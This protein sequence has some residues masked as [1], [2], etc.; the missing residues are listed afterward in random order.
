MNPLILCGMN[1]LYEND[2]V[3]RDLKPENI[4]YR[5]RDSDSD[6]VIAN[7]RIICI[8]L[9]SSMKPWL[10]YSRG[11]QQDRARETSGKF[12]DGGEDIQMKIRET[13]R[14][15]VSDEAKTFIKVLLNLDPSQRPA[16]EMAF[17]HHI[18][19]RHSPLRQAA[20]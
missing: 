2:T 15:K 9:K 5:I 1:Y 17:R 16:Q 6:I 20:Q 3:R 11:S 18:R 8:H 13:T 19:A 10:C 14:A 12:V 7:F 4:L